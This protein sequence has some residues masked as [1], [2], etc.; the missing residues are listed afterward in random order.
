MKHVNDFA[1]TL[2]LQAVSYIAQQ[3]SLLNQFLTAVGST[4]PA[5]KKSLGQEETLA[6]VLDWL[7]QN[8]T[9]LIEFCQD[10]DVA[11]DMIWRARRMLPGSPEHNY[12][13]V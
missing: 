9:T 6:A 8:E 3:E 7:L 5:L 10:L 1:H 12:Q 11:P 2:A 4:L 13:S